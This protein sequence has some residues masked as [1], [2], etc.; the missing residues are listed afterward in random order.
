MRTSIRIMTIH[1]NSNTAPSGTEIFELPFSRMRLLKKDNLG[2]NR[3]F[4]L[5]RSSRDGRAGVEGIRL[6]R[7]LTNPMAAANSRRRARRPRREQERTPEPNS[8]RDSSTRLA[9]KDISVLIEVH[10]SEDIPRQRVG[11]LKV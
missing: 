7:L 5:L 2:T 9:Q 6:T 4:S 3:S 11:V 8:I 1:G 10:R